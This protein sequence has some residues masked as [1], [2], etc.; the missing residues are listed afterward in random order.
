MARAEFR[1]AQERDRYA[2]HVRPVNEL[3]DR[4]RD[5]DGRGWMP[6]VAPWHGGVEARVLSVLRDPGRATQ[7][8]VGS[9]FLCIEN[10]DP[11]A[12]RQALAFAQAGI[13]PR[14][15]TPWNAYPWFK[16]SQT[17]PTGAEL[18]AGVD[19]L[20]ELLDL[21]PHVQ[22]VLLQGKEAQSSWSRAVRRRPSLRDVARSGALTVIP[23]YHPA[24]GALR[25]P[26][27][28]ERERRQTHRDE[29]YRAAAEALL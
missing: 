27:P 15:V 29:A 19:P 16:E 25:H 5:R 13:E 1:Q 24:R 22:V 28:E 20:L 7:D 14:D 8:G 17:P 21:M 9:G 4:L 6:H 18:N 12:E 2:P 26:D 11:T 23:T 3:V 10:D